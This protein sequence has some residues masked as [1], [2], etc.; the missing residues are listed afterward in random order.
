METV[1]KGI[2]QGLQSIK[3][4]MKNFNVDEIT[5]MKS[6]END[7]LNFVANEKCER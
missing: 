2:V 4:V 5:A 1:E 7:E 6:L 3:N